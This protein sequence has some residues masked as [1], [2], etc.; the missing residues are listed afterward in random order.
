M[1]RTL[2]FVKTRRAYYPKEMC[3]VKAKYLFLIVLFLIFAFFLPNTPAQDYTK[4]HLPEGAKAP[5][6]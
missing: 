3:Q 1:I 4:W 2:Q 6:W 5:P